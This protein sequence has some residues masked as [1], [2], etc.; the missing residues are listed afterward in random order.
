VSRHS[1]PAARSLLRQWISPE[2]IR[3]VPTRVLE[4][5][6]NPL[7]RNAYALLL[8]NALTSGLGVIY[9][10]LAARL[11][12]SRSVGINAA[13]ISTMTFLS[14][15]SQLNLRVALNRL[16][17]DAGKRTARLIGLSYASS[18]LA[19]IAVCALFFALPIFASVRPSELDLQLSI[20]FAVATAAW[21]IFNIQDGVLTGLRRATWVP[22]EN[23]SYSLVK[24][25]LLV[26][27]AA[28]FPTY[29]IFA[30]WTVPALVAIALVS[31]ALVTMFI[32]RHLESRGDRILSMS[33]RRLVGFVGAD[34]IASLMA[35]SYIALLPLVVVAHAGAE[36]A[37]HFYVVWV[38]IASVNLIPAYMAA[39][40]T[41]ESMWWRGNLVRETRRTMWHTIR[42]VFP[43]AC[44]LFLLGPTILE[45]F[46]RAYAE[47]GAALLRLFSL[48]LPFYAVNMTFFGFA[49]IRGVITP[50]VVIQGALAVAIL[51]GAWLLIGVMGLEGIAVAWLVSH[52]AVALYLLWGPFRSMA[53]LDA[54]GGSQRPSG[55]E[56][57]DS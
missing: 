32:P 18:L 15:V 27:F 13:L 48:S 37:A 31:L 7:F 35:L 6:R 11:Y 28:V 4:H 23:G 26:A 49:R 36:A 10:A 29:G 54:T 2:T 45:L 1:G 22:V 38:I 34:Y 14:G 16:L 41:V 44:V 3:A 30:S 51:G 50:I 9:W 55:G 56:L 5:L 20:A 57:Q 19:A 33:H 21:A 47:R 53:A 25:L 52:T 46:G 40:L 8:S 42:I 43:I 24:I 39:S 17:P 12:D